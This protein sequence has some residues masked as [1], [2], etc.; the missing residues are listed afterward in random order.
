MDIKTT[1]CKNFSKKKKNRK[2][3]SGSGTRTLELEFLDL[4]P[5]TCHKKNI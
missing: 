3:A 4:M 1:N 5:K 2:T